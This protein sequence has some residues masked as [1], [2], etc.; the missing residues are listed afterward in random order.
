[1]KKL[2]LILFLAL[3]STSAWAKPCWCSKY[4][5]GIYI[6]NN[7]YAYILIV[8]N[9]RNWAIVTT[10]PQ[11]TDMDNSI[12]IWF[13]ATRQF[14]TIPQNQHWLFRRIKKDKLCNP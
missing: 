14:D 3:V 5:Y 1:M 6:D 9:G 13:P 2:A 10:D 4:K 7:D 8:D 11:A 12:G